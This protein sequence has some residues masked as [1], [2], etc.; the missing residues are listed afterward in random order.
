MSINAKKNIKKILTN[1]VIGGIILK[2]SV[3]KMVQ[4]AQFDIKHTVGNTFVCIIFQV[5]S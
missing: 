3:R 1:T 4:S 5:V 2:L